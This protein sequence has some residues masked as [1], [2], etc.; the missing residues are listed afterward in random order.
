MPLSV[1]LFHLLYY[2][3]YESKPEVRPDPEMTNGCSHSL[4]EQIT[5]KLG[6]LALIYGLKLPETFG[7]KQLDRLEDLTRYSDA[8][9]ILD[10]VDY[11]L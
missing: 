5:F 10:E 8:G 2:S 11:S 3:R 9:Y 6:L 4:R 7:Q 1:E